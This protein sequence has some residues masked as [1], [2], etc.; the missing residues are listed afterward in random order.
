MTQ[1]EEEQPA[2]SFYEQLGGATV[3]A[4]LVKRFYANMDTLPEAEPIRRMHPDQLSGSE[5]KL[6]KFLSGWLGGPNLYIEEFG[7]PRL[8]MR[9]LPFAIGT[10]ARDQW[11]LCMKKALDDTIDDP[12][13]RQHLY[14]ALDQTATHMINQPD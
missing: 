10:A 6:F 3:L 9:H 8:R 12:R 7:H 1:P 13:L 11:L 2:S 4:T 14:N 5:S